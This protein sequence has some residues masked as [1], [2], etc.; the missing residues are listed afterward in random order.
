MSLPVNPEKINDM[1]IDLDENTTLEIEAKVKDISKTDFHVLS[2]FFLQNFKFTDTFS[3]DTYDEMGGRI[4]EEKERFYNTT[5]DN[6][7][8][9]K[10]MYRGTVVKI[11]ISKEK[12]ELLEIEEVENFKFKREKK[13]R[14]FI[15]NNY[16]YD[17]TEVTEIPSGKTSYE[18]EIEIIDPKKV[19][20]K[21]FTQVIE[22]SIDFIKSYMDD[23]YRFCNKS[24]SSGRIDNSD[25]IEYSLVST[26]R[27]LKK[28]DLTSE[29]SIL[30]G[31]N[32]SIKADGIQYFLVFHKTGIWLVSIRQEKTE[33]IC[34]FSEEFSHLEN[35]MFVGEIINREKII[36]GNTI[37]SNCVYLPYDTICF[38]NKIVVETDYDN[39][40]SFLKQIKDILFKCDGVNKIRVIEK[41]IFSLGTT[42]KSF[43]EGFKKCYESKKDLIY[44]NDGYIFTPVKSPFVAEGQFKK[45]WERFL[46]KNLDVCKFKPVEKRSIDLKVSD[47]K[48]Y[49]KSGR[50]LEEFSLL[51]FD[52]N[53]QESLDEK[54]V[55][56]FPDFS[57]GKVKLVPERIRSDKIFPNKKDIIEEIV[58]SY[59]EE[60]PITEETLLGKNTVL[61]RDFNNKIKNELISSLEGYVVDMGSGKGGDM[62]K[63]SNNEKIKKVL[64]VEP[65]LEFAKEHRKRLKNFKS[66][67]KFS[68]LPGVKAEETEKISKGVIEFLPNSMEGEKLTITF[69][70]SLSFFWS[71]DVKLNSLAKTLNEINEIYKTRGGEESVDVVFLTIEGDR[72]RK[73]FKNW[74]KNSITLNTITLT[75]GEGNQLVVDIKDSKTV[76][77]Q[78]EYLVDLPLLYKKA[79]MEKDFLKS[80]KVSKNLLMTTSEAIYINLFVYGKY[81]LTGMGKFNYITERLEVNTK[82]G[83]SVDGK[84]LAKGEDVF[85][86][87][88]FIDPNLFR[89][90][91]LDLSISLSHS[92]SK[93]LNEKYRDGN[94]TDRIKIS[95]DFNKIIKD[96]DMEQLSDFMEY[97]IKIYHGKNERKYGLEKDKWI[98]LNECSDNSFEP[99][100]YKT[101]IVHYSFGKNSFLI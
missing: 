75:L 32:V 16:S 47:K 88:T 48:L 101:D 7:Y 54:I 14:S 28:K 93:L 71:S 85:S 64:A 58:F 80:P 10:K 43:F 89:I 66:S 4:T 12:K 68:L 90:A 84:L 17:M 61:M 79:G 27:D 24:L 81:S 19:N 36:D 9:N 51:S 31:F 55:E 44:L 67:N 82:K 56:F 25:K 59:K 39:R 21:E 87:L 72:V 37:D 33:R 69:M 74:G 78:I 91:T 34:D 45:K 100:V 92:I 18:F 30:R 62:F 46:F 94:V 11:T 38:N 23:V 77:Q 5:K 96:F 60:N 6:V 1:L 98:I 70:I 99:V 26:A 83:K 95:K 63:F 97:G 2:D 40:I 49:Y 53:F 42:S 29:N 73:L 8:Y 22:K 50:N 35:S 3:I 20:Y 41:K 52:L 65:N 13:R 76:S 15:D 57:E 86:P